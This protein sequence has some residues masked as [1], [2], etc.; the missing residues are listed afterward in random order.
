MKQMQFEG[1]F[2][3]FGFGFGFV[4]VELKS[5]IE[6]KVRWESG[7]VGEVDV[8]VDFDAVS[9]EEEDFEGEAEV[10]EGRGAWRVEVMDEVIFCE[11]WNRVRR[12]RDEVGIV[13]EEETERSE[14]WVRHESRLRRAVLS[15]EM[16]AVVGTGIVEPD[17][18]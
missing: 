3:L 5:L 4:L 12:L 8:D 13:E 16:V 6:D 1:S 11:V 2:V 18:G 15:G 9:G 7:V 14:F 10:D 17:I